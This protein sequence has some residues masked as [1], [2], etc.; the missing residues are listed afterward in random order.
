[1]FKLNITDEKNPID[2]SGKEGMQKMFYIDCM[3]VKSETEKIN[4][5]LASGWN[6]KKIKK[7]DSGSIIIIEY[8]GLD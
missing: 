6:V 1:M 3:S 2:T 4:A 8:V 7:I 5:F